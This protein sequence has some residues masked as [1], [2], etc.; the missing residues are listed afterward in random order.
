MPLSS[1]SEIVKALTEFR[2]ADIIGAAESVSIDFKRSLYQLDQDK[3]R[4]AFCTDVAAMAN[5]SGGILVCGFVADKQ[6]NEVHECASAASPV[7]LSRLKI[8]SYGDVLLRY[9]WPHVDVKFEFY[10]QSAEDQDNGFFVI[11]VE[12]LPEHQRYV[13]VRQFLNADGR[14]CEGFTVPIRHGDRTTYLPT[15]VLHRLMTDAHRVRDFPAAIAQPSAQTRLSD[16]ELNERMEA[17]TRSGPTASWAEEQFPVLFWQST[18]DRPAGLV[19]G[20]YD[21]GGVYGVLADHQRTLRPSGFHF[22]SMY[23]RP[24]TDS[25]ALVM[26][27]SR[28]AV[29]VDIDGTVT[30][31]AVVT[32]DMLAWNMETSSR[33]GK[34]RLH[35]LALTEMTLE[36]FRLVDENILP[37]VSGPWR[38]RIFAS[39]FKTPNEVTLADGNGLTDWGYGRVQEATADEWDQTWLADG[40]PERDAYE[41]LKRLYALFGMSEKGNSF[42]TGDR[43]DAKKM[44]AALNR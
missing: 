35:I 40:D 25:G 18:P 3:G 30:A 13:V 21:A 29:R 17:L 32:N 5:A 39:R 34:G 24:R 15:E 44:L 28:W 42:I 26:A 8:D 37:R 14:L 43:V 33:G 10:P 1:R 31:G 7:P 38:H 12:P 22:A 4:H 9:L 11:E 36:Y 16:A 41:A 19:D 20:L 27:D 6:P 23:E 2:H